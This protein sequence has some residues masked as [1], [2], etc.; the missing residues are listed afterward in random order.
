MQL[1]TI[2]GRIYAPLVFL[3]LALGLSS[4]RKGK[5]DPLIS[6]H[7]RK[8]RVAGGWAINNYT[9]EQNTVY[10]YPNNATLT[11]SFTQ[12][13]GQVNYSETTSDTAT[14]FTVR[15]GKI[16]RSSYYFDKSGNWILIHNNLQRPEAN[17]GN[18]L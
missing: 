11:K 1:F 14:S 17:T 4:C 10:I 18:I 15:N 7:S 9:R 8:D 16:G 13:F 12:S 2:P 3:V 6:F 5:E